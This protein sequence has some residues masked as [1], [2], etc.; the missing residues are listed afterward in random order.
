[1]N[2]EI[3]PIFYE[4]FVLHYFKFESGFFLISSNV[5]NFLNFKFNSSHLIG[6]HFCRCCGGLEAAVFGTCKISQVA[7][8]RTLRIFVGR[9]VHLRCRL[10]QNPS[11]PTPS[12]NSSLFF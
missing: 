5:L 10:L 4:I 2:L 11:F 7:K 1:M 3:T 9:T 6:F 12:I 8:F